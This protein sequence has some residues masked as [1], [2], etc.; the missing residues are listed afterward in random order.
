M[1]VRTS[2][3]KGNQEQIRETFNVSGS[4]EVLIVEE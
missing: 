4:E 3:G 2:G 1:N